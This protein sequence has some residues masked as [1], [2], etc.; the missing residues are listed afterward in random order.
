MNINT[1]T[2]S[3][4]TENKVLTDNRQVHLQPNVLEELESVHV[5]HVDI[6]YNDIKTIFVLS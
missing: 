3:E 2:P 4:M 1:L 6:A 5:G